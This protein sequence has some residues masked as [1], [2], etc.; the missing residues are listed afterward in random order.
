[1]IMDETMIRQLIADHFA[2]AGKDEPAAAEIF[3]DDAVVEWPQ[4]GERIRGKPQLVAVHQASPTRADFDIRRTIG[5]G[6]P[7]RNRAHHTGSTLR[8]DAQ[9]FPRVHTCR[10]S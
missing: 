6:D 2:A 10:R 3:A 7:G 1:M 8:V 9:P 4:S 5:C